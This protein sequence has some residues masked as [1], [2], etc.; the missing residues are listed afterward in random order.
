MRAA[1]RIGR[2]PPEVLA[3]LAL[4]TRVGCLSVGSTAPA[5]RCL[6]QDPADAPAPAGAIPAFAGNAALPAALATAGLVPAADFDPAHRIVRS[7]TGQVRCDAKSGILTV[8]TPTSIAAV[9]P[10]H[11]TVELEGVAITNQDADP[12]T[13]VVASLDGLPL[14]RSKRLLA[15]LLTDAQSSGIRFAS[16]RHNLVEAWGGAPVLVRAGQVAL[17]AAALDGMQAWALDLSGIRREQ[18]PCTAGR[19]DAAVA[20]SWGPCLAWELVRAP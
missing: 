10:G 19:L 6:I 5:L 9:L 17:T 8:A 4:H 12:V 18:V 1:G 2:Q 16:P 14:G 13:V 3:A 15:L 20:R 7:A 11:G